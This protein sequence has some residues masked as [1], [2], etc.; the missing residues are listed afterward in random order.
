MCTLAICLC[1]LLV[2]HFFFVLS[3]V[4]VCVF[5]REWFFNVSS[6]WL[7]T[8]LVSRALKIPLVLSA[9]HLYSY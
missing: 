7:K 1:Q 2:L 9:Y 4:C 6:K 5:Y 3:G 8:I